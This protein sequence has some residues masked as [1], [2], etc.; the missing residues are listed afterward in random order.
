MEVRAQLMVIIQRV[1]DFNSVYTHTS[2]PDRETL[3]NVAL[4]RFIST[5]LITKKHSSI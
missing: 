2:Y 3:D 4:N 1:L 5:Q